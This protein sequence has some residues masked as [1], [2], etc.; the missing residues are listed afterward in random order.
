MDTDRQS[1]TDS[2][3]LALPLRGPEGS[4]PVRDAGVRSGASRVAVGAAWA[5]GIGV[6]LLAWLLPLDRLPSACAMRRL[7]G[8]PCLTCGM[9]RSLHALLHG[10]AAG[11]WRYHPLLIVF[12]GIGAL[13]LAVV[14]LPARRRGERVSPRLSLAASALA[15]LLLIGVWALRLTR[16]GIP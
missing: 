9:G 14:A 11:S 12:L 1:E 15:L 2:P 16:G 13:W 7:T 8:V 6:L 5:A 4:A 3:P 10:D